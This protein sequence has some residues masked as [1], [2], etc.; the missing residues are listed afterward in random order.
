MAHCGSE[1]QFSGQDPNVC[2]QRCLIYKLRYK[3][4]RFLINEHFFLNSREKPTKIIS[5]KKKIIRRR[6]TYQ[7]IYR[8]TYQF[9]TKI[10][11]SSKYRISIENR[12]NLNQ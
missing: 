9:E 6:N 4:V 1:F 10:Q 5:S 12:N 3:R 8:N 11:I 2:R 7:Y